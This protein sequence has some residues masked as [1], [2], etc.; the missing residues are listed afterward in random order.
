[1]LEISTPLS[2]RDYREATPT[3]LKRAEVFSV[4][5]VAI[6]LPRNGWTCRAG[7]ISWSVESVAL[8]GTPVPYE[9]AAFYHYLMKDRSYEY[10]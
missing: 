4:Q 7:D 2:K 3:S 6:V 9:D 8:H 1:M 10:G 5:L